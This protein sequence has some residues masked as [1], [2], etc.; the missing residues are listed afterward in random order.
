[1]WLR[2]CEGEPTS[3]GSEL[4]SSGTASCRG[5]GSLRNR[6]H[7][8]RPLSSRICGPLLPGLVF[9]EPSPRSR[10][11]RKRSPHTAALPGTSRPRARRRSQ[12]LPWQG[13]PPL[14]PCSPPLLEQRR[15][16]RASRIAPLFPP[17]P[18]GSGEPPL[19][20]TQGAQHAP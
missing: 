10:G 17:P 18:Y 20:T 4:S 1:M 11:S 8:K 13:G 6:A 12:S 3:P 7:P 19:A 5:G 9:S 15:R 14:P 16:S 2:S